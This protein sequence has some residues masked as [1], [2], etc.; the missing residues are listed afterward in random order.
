MGSTHFSFLFSERKAEENVWLKVANFYNSYR[1][2][3]LA[4]LNKSSSAYPL[5]QTPSATARVSGAPRRVSEDDLPV[6][7]RGS[8][9]LVK[10]I[11]AEGVEAMKGK[12]DEEGTSSLTVR[13]EVG[14]QGLFFLI[15][16]VSIYPD[17]RITYRE[18]S[19]VFI[20]T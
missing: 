18:R 8:I 5:P 17:Y 14:V 10:D 4:E 15:H 6:V 11:L 20:N 3:V 13:L 12:A 1:A 9:R 2:S 16:F 19:I 7:F